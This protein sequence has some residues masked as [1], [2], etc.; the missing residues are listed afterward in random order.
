[1]L[2]TQIRRKAVYSRTVSVKEPFRL[3]FSSDEWNEV[4]SIQM[5]KTFLVFVIFAVILL[6]V[7]IGSQAATPVLVLLPNDGSTPCLDGTPGGYYWQAALSSDAHN[8]W[9]L[10]FEGGGM[11]FFPSRL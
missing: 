6:G 9:I 5:N 4:Q 3:F 1:M 8:K 2:K 10:F 7:V 11:S